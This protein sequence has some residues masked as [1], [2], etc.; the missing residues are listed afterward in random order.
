M[1]AAAVG[2]KDGLTLY[3]KD[4]VNHRCKNMAGVQFGFSSLDG[5]TVLFPKL[6]GPALLLTRH[7][8]LP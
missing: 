5:S 8:R 6:F 1:N 2:E 3:A 4:A 7:N